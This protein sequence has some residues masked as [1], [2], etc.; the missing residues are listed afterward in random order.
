MAGTYS[1]SNPVPLTVDKGG[2]GATTL[3]DHGVLLGSGTGAITPL[4][5]MSSGQL[6]IGSSGADPVLATLGA[7]TNISITNG[8]GTIS[9]ATSGA[10]SFT[11]S[12]IVANQTAAVNNG[13]ICNKG[14]TLA[15]L[16]PAT[17][18]VGDLL[19]VTGINTV[20]GIQ[21]TQAAGQQIFFGLLSTTLGATGTL[22]STA[23]RDSL[24]L[25][26]VVTNTVWNVV[27]SVGNWTVA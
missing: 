27:S 24:K 20:L 17:S 4:G 3:T 25:V 13:Y 7:G 23:I 2:T 22:T 5:A 14:T 1:L 15:L 19:E 9:I 8:A 10:A 6:V 11:W 26:C 16:L 18:A 12:V 21:I